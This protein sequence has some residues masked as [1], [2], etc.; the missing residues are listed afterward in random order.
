MD[1]EKKQLVCVF[2]DGMDYSNIVLDISGAMEWI[3]ADMQD[4]SEGEDVSDREYTIRLAW[5]T[6]SEIDNLPEA[7]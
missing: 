7:E 2:S 4:I 1:N 6:Q 5:M 3:K